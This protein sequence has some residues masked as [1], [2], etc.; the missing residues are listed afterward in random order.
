MGQGERRGPTRKQDLTVTGGLG[1]QLFVPYNTYGGRTPNLTQPHC[2]VP[3][4]CNF[5]G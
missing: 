5:D 4:N 1:Q 2:V 3:R